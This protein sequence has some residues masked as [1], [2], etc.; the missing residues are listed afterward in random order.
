MDLTTKDNVKA[1]IGLTGSG[2]DVLIVA[3]VKAVSA[4][5]TRY[6]KREVAIA[7]RTEF[8]DVEPGQKVFLLK[9]YPVTAC[10]VYNDEA[11][12]F[13]TPLGADVYTFLGSRGR[14]VVDDY[15][16]ID[17][18]QVLKVVYTGGLAASQEAL[19][20][21]YPDIEMAARIQT[22]YVYDRRKKLGL[23]SESFGNGSVQFE[24]KLE[25]LPTVK[26]M[27]DPHRRKAYAG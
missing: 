8:H 5:I 14:I 23:A 17:G 19:E 15:P 26:E 27:L 9:A 10:A 13:T 3:L 16:L 20:T 4:Q 12:A 1:L 18:A 11:R 6:M 7:E 22:A 24:Q 2:D 25:I 21:Q